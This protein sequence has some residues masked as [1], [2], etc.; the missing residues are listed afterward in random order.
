M[1]PREELE[2]L[3]RLSELE[4]RAAKP[5]KA[6][7]VERESPTSLTNLAGAAVEPN[8]TLLTGA[9]SGPLSGY[10][11]M[12]GAAL[13][14]PEGQGSRWASSVQ[15]A[16]TYKPVTQGGRA[17][18]QVIG[19]PF[20]Q[21]AKV[22]DAAGG[23][24]AEDLDSPAAGAAINAAIQ[25]GIP[26]AAG[27][28]APASRSG[29][30]GMG[31]VTDAAARR[32]MT[33]AVKPSSAD[34][35]SGA[36]ARAIQTML[37]E[38]I[39]PTPGGMR[40]IQAIASRL[41]DAVAQEIANSPATVSVARAAAPLRDLHQRA[42]N[43]VNPNA[44]IAAVRAA[45]DE[46]RNSPAVAGRTDIPV[47][48]AHELKRGTYRALG[49]RN[50]GEL[51][52]ASTEAQKGIARGLREE[53]L[54]AVPQIRADLAREAALRNVLG[55]VENKANM[56]TNNNPMGLAS[57]R[58]DSLAPYIASTLDRSATL[59]GV[60]ARALYATGDPNLMRTALGIA[61]AEEGNPQYTPVFATG[62]NGR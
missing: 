31:N 54:N 61:A 1:T 47:Q 40:R 46:F 33:S 42:T 62:I 18:A 28:L 21:L 43:Q 34:H 35:A 17:A 16:L 49:D 23:K 29:V 44:D 52:G 6:A 56:Q 53:V 32:L 55:V 11:G 25:A 59:K 14:G 37:D 3:R 38:G 9:V 36:A 24:V 7:P 60:L 27:R 5:A 50:Y 51:T 2:A 19:Y 22:A 26:V 8:L 41:D 13:P 20:E 4:A 12:L 15:N 39:N 30:T 10:V 58:V 45:W 57:L 48:T